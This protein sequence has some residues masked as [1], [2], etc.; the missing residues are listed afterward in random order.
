MNFSKDILNRKKSTLIFKTFKEKIIKKFNLIDIIKIDALVYYYLIRNKEN[1]FFSLIINK[2]Y[3]TFYESFS[4]KSM[5][6][7]NRIS[8]NKRCLCDFEIKYKRYCESY[9]LKAIQINNVKV[10]ISQKMLNKFFI[11]YYDYANVF[12]KLKANVLFSHRFYDYKLKFVEEINKNALSKNRI[13]LLSDHKFE[14]IKK[15]LNK[16]L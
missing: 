6:K 10:F 2:I 11:N 4:T 12:D 16:H 8:F 5:Q 9:T 14:Q 1:K 15:Y 3:N 13:Y 7:N